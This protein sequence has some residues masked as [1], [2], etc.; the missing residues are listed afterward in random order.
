MIVCGVMSGTSLDGI[1][2]I[3]ADIAP[4]SPRLN[5]ST[6]FNQ[7]YPFSVSLRQ[8]LQHLVDGEAM[9]PAALAAT[10][11]T[12]EAEVSVAILTAQAEIGNSIELVGCH[13]Q[14]I[15]HRPRGTEDTMA[16]TLGGQWPSV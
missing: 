4:G 10:E 13:G 6:L 14:T 1:D 2:V 15:Y 8:N 7:T 11:E 16:L 3:I 5:I 9:T 12:Y